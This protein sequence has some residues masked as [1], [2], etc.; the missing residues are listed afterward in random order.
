[1]DE[2]SLILDSDAARIEP[3]E[4]MQFAGSLTE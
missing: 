3:V 2:E 1:M 4:V